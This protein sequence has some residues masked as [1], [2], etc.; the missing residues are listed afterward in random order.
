MWNHLEISF[1]D[2]AIAV[3]R[4]LD[5]VVEAPQCRIPETTGERPRHAGADVIPCV[6]RFGCD[7]LLR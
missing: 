2:A 7:S 5:T 4:L 6:S 3:P 1:W